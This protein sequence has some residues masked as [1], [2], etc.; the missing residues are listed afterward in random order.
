MSELSE[1]ENEALASFIYTIWQVLKRCLFD[2]QGQ[3]VFLVV[4]TTLIILGAN[5][6]ICIIQLWF[7]Q[8]TKGDLVLYKT[9]HDQSTKGDLIY[10]IMT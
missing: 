1:C 9:Q 2:G 3:L 7:D 5:F 8:S 6:S 10:K 4:K